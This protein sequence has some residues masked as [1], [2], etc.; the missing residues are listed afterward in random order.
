MSDDERYFVDHGTIH[1]RVTGKHVELEEAAGML[2]VEPEAMQRVAWGVVVQLGA[3]LKNAEVERDRLRDK[4]NAYES[5]LE[6]W[7]WA[8]LARDARCDDFESAAEALDCI[9]RVDE[10]RKAQP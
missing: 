9:A 8:G 4:V 7:D 2:S 6:D 10:W 1:D 3:K 5:A